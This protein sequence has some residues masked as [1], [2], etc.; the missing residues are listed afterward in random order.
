MIYGLYEEQ[1][2]V[3]DLESRRQHERYDCTDVSVMYTPFSSN[4]LKAVNSAV[5]TAKLKDISLSGL[6]IQVDTSLSV[7]DTLSISVMDASSKCVEELNVEVMWFKMTED[8]HYNVGLRVVQEQDIV[9]DA[10][11]EVLYKSAPS[12]TQN[13]ICPSCNETSFY[14]PA[15]SDESTTTVLHTCCRCNHSHPITQVIAFNRD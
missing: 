13:L 7:G 15:V 2:E 9:F 6:C 4:Y 3:D 12:L 14:M 11:E 8:K 5:H 10:D 1:A